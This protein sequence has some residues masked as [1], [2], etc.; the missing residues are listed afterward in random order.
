MTNII[1]IRNILVNAIA[2]IILS[3]PAI[4]ADDPGIP[5]SIIV[6]NLDGSHYRICPGEEVTVPIW[7]KNDED[8]GNI[9]IPV[10]ADSQYIVEW[11]SGNIYGQIANWPILY[12][13]EAV[14]N[15]PEVGFTTKFLWGLCAWLDVPPEDQIPL[16]TNGNWERVADIIVT[17][18]SEES[19]IGSSVQF[20]IGFYPPL[21]ALGFGDPEGE[22]T[23]FP[24][25]KGGLI[26]V[27][28][29]PYEY[30]P[31]DVNMHIGYW[32]PQVTNADVTY[33]VNYFRG[34]PSS[35]PCLLDEFWASADINGD[36]QVIG[37]DVSRLINYFKGAATILFCPDYE[38]L[39]P[40]SDDLP[41]EA[42][43]GWPNCE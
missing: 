43:P 28:H 3:G 17:I 18:N 41:V 37:S 6:G 10:A 12:F 35:V 31:G 4:L 22:A 25:F 20:I 2:I 5:D 24:V 39:W 27:V 34:F 7:V 33:L 23:W 13:E 38:P 14:E 42:P 32:Q 36:C 11:T 9:A 29:P 40:T 8:I 21:G 26:D 30:L 16:N 1:K 15:E 19:L